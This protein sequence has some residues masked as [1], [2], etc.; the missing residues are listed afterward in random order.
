M[1]PEQTPVGLRLARA[2]RLVGRAFDDALGEAGGSLPVWLV[3]LN[4]KIRRV[5]SQRELAD[6]VGVTAPTLTHH[7]GG[8]EADGLLVRRRDPDNRRNHIIELTEL[9]EQGFVRLR[10]AAVAFDA[11]LRAGFEPDELAALGAQLE[12]LCANVADPEAGPPWSGIIEP[13]AR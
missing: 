2:S 6:A 13:K 3:L 8:M 4:L 5:A 7:L 1:R 9:G 12:R 11:R 10:D